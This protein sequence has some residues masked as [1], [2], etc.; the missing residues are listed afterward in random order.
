MTKNN[1]SKSILIGS[2]YRSPASTVHLLRRSQLRNAAARPGA[3]KHA[4]SVSSDRRIAEA[5]YLDTL[6][7]VDRY[8]VGDEAE[9]GPNSDGD[10][11]DNDSSS[12][13]EDP[14]NWDEEDT[15]V[16]MLQQS[17]VYLC[18]GMPRLAL[19]IYPITDTCG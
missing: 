3:G 12:E 1:L 5:R 16:A 18:L 9:Y 14:V 10:E 11:A 13:L 7:K 2:H 17:Y 8:R 4:L 6:P 15:I 19:R